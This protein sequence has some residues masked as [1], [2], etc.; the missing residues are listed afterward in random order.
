MSCFGFLLTGLEDK[1]DFPYAIQALKR[2][3]RMALW[4]VRARPVKQRRIMA[5]FAMNSLPFEI[6]HMI[7]SKANL[8]GGGTPHSGYLW[9]VRMVDSYSDS[10]ESG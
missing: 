1:Y 9:P 6:K 7:L 2:L 10:D 3:F 4:A 8:V 5:L